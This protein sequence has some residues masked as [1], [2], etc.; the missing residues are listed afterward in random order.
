M[1][2]GGYNGYSMSNR[3]VRAYDRGLLPASKIKQVPNELIR[4]Y[5]S[6][7]EWHHTSCKYNITEFY[8]P[9]KV[10]I[11]FGLLI[12]TEDHPEYEDYR[13]YSVDPEAVKALAEYKVEKK[14]AK[15]SEKIYENC[16]IYWT[17]WVGPFRHAK[18]KMC[19][20]TGRVIVRSST[21]YITLSGGH[22]FTKRLG[23]NG[24]SFKPILNDTTK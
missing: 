21:A 24:F 13:D 8:D 3:A 10:L 9:T 15:K 22:E 23:S 2:D 18:P 17:I 6:S 7:E 14:A 16:D 20:A 4:E 11:K 12:I 5:C 19:H 1:F